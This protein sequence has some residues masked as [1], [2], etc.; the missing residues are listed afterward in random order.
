MVAKR[1]RPNHL[2]DA[3][4]STKAIIRVTMYRRSNRAMPMMATICL[5]VILDLLC[6][7]FIET[8]FFADGILPVSFAGG[9]RCRF[10]IAFVHGFDN[11]FLVFGEGLLKFFVVFAV[12][13][14]Y[15][16]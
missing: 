5:D 6:L 12:N 7:S 3:E 11:S 4:L 10:I 1:Q 16:I 14:L 15:T 8:S 9:F 2:P 13:M